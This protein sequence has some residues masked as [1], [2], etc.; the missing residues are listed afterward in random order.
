[1]SQLCSWKLY[2][3]I[4]WYVSTYKLYI[5]ALGL[6]LYSCHIFRVIHSVLIVTLTHHLATWGLDSASGMFSSNL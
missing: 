5:Q 1:M 6:N 3:T 2:S 4:V